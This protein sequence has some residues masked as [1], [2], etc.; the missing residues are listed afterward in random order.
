[1]DNF[2][3]YDPLI[4]FL[5]IVISCL[6]IVFLTELKDFYR[7]NYKLLI[8]F[9]FSIVIILCIRFSTSLSEGLIWDLRDIPLVFGTIYGGPLVGAG[10]YAVTVLY[11]LSLGGL[12]IYTTIFG[13]GAEVLAAILLF[14]SYHSLSFRKKFLTGTGLTL[15]SPLITGVTGLFLVQLTTELVIV[16]LFD[17]S[18]TLIS[19]MVVM[20]VILLLT[21]S[22]QYKEKTLVAEKNEMVAHLS[23][24]INHELKNPLTTVFGFLQ[25]LQQTEQDAQ[26][27]QY[28]EISI[29]ELERAKSLIS[30]YLAFAKPHSEK[31][32]NLNLKD[33]LH[34]VLQ[35]V[36]PLANQHSITLESDL[37]D[38]EIWAD[39]QG[40]QQAFMNFLLNSIE[41]AALVPAGGKISVTS[42]IFN[43]KVKLC[44]E[45]NGV[46][47]DKEQISRLGQPYF[48][49]KGQSGTGLGLMV[50]Y[51]IIKN[52][53]G[54]VTV[55]SSIN[56]GT[57][58]TIELPLAESDQ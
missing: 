3:Y 41:A 19:S 38:C 12:G 53:G 32:E 8:F 44:I 29:S 17:F 28:I 49:T 26:K 58:F 35:V 48:T 43:R 33:Q 9:T 10:L 39:K 23:A 20:L 47:M 55:E 11:R 24:S 31:V 51:S 34:Y 5:L 56:K 37:E 30:N 36:K 57:T 6:I 52:L 27:K 54:E 25:L 13:N 2:Q 14:K 40:L 46:G 4:N 42:F 15:I 18:L 7:K 1:M 22:L 16:W 45:D 50:S 21:R